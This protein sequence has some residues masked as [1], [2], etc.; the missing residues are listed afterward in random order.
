MVIHYS[1]TRIV[2]PRQGFEDI[3]EI[4]REENLISQGIK[5]VYLLVGRADLLSPPLQVIKNME[6][7]LGGMANLQPK[8]M[9]VV[10]ALIVLPSDS[11]KER[12]NILEI[13]Q[14]IAKMV[15]RDHHWVFFNPNI[16]VSIA[17]EPQKRFFDRE[18]R[19]NRAG[20]RFVAQ[21]LVATSKSARMLQ[22]FDLLPPKQ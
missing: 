17:G 15:E 3:L 6:R 5:V 12:A 21:A 20:C 7:L 1:R 14:K 22:N 11:L 2:H 8:I 10:G 16:S 19:I 18:N 9:V 13:N 4:L